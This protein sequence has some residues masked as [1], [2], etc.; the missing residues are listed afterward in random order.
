MYWCFS[1]MFISCF[2]CEYVCDS[3][4][5]PDVSDSVMH[6]KHQMYNTTVKEKAISIS[7]L[8]VLKGQLDKS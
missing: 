8:V 5:F 1:V 4:I 3:G 2:L 6:H 7:Y